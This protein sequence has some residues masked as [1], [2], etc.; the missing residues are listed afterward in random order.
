M[1]T[2]ASSL[3]LPLELTRPC[4]LLNTIDMRCNPPI[5][6]F[7]IV[8]SMSTLRHH[9]PERERLLVGVLFVPRGRASAVHVNV[10]NATIV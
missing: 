7:P 3:S 4:P 1:L 8:R 10:P 9:L 6:P 2:Y 5:P